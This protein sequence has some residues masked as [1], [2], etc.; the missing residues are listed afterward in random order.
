[1]HKLESNHALVCVVMALFQALQP[2]TGFSWFGKVFSIYNCTCSS[3]AL[4]F[5]ALFDAHKLFEPWAQASGDKTSAEQSMFRNEQFTK[6][7]N[8]ICLTRI[9]VRL[10]FFTA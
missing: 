7:Y 9:V 6:A 8:S 5:C 3:V 4:V 2:G 1:M 10:L